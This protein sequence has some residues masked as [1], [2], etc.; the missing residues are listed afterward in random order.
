MRGRKKRGDGGEQE[1]EVK[2]GDE[3]ERK[4]EGEWGEGEGRYMNNSCCILQAG[5][6]M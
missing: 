6:R 5:A 2:E 3:K 4:S 1:G